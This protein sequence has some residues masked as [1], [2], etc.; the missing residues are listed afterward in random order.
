V[1]TATSAT[2]DVDIVVGIPLSKAQHRLAAKGIETV[3]KRGDPLE[4]DSPA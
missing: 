1:H 3:L 2:K 4:G